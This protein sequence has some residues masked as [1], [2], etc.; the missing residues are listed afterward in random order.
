MANDILKQRYPNINAKGFIEL[1]VQIQQLYDGPWVIV[2]NCPEEGC[3]NP[4]PQDQARARNKWR[5]AYRMLMQYED[6]II[7]EFNILDTPVSSYWND[8]E[9]KQAVRAMWDI[10]CKYHDVVELWDMTEGDDEPESKKEPEKKEE[11][12]YEKMHNAHSYL[13]A[14]YDFFKSEIFPAV[15]ENTHTWVLSLPEDSRLDMIKKRKEAVRTNLIRTD[16]FMHYP[17]TIP[18]QEENMIY[19]AFNEPELSEVMHDTFASYALEDMFE[20][21]GILNVDKVALHL[22]EHKDEIPR[23]AV[24]AF[25]KYI[26]LT[27]VLNGYIIPN[28]V[29]DTFVANIS[30]KKPAPFDTPVTAEPEQ[31]AYDMDKAMDYYSR[32]EATFKETVL[33]KLKQSISRWWNRVTPDKREDAIKKRI[34]SYENEMR[35]SDFLSYYLSHIDNAAIREIYEYADDGYQAQRCVEDMQYQEDMNDLF[36]G[37]D[38]LNVEKLERYIWVNQKRLSDNQIFAFLRYIEMK[39]YLPTLIVNGEC[40]P[41]NH[42]VK[43]EIQIP[44]EKPILGTVFSPALCKNVDASKA[45]IKLVKEK[46]DPSH[47]TG[48]RADRWTWG[49]MQEAF[50]QVGFVEATCDNAAFGRAMVEINGELKADNVKAACQRFSSKK[51]ANSD[52]NLIAKLVAELTTIKNMLTE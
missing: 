46:L 48:K 14:S 43:D 36:D 35:Q 11:T 31:V 16:F 29:V 13:N 50:K 24:S 5:K 1:A 44:V 21:V 23:T 25:F 3:Y 17:A 37:I 6:Q 2:G 42:N 4:N 22:Y 30:V 33:P 41:D 7:R 45:L 28:E 9:G 47:C 40:L 19:E 10:C 34:E 12:Y 27:K 38:I 8:D 20:G 52:K 32:K 51:A 26:E 15:E 39:E 49:H 18:A